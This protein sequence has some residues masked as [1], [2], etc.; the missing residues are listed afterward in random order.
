[1]CNPLDFVRNC[2]NCAFA[3]ESMDGEHC[4]PCHVSEAETGVPYQDWQPKPV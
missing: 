3:T 1:M 2:G 4:N